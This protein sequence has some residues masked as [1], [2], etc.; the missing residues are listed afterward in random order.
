M[1]KKCD[2]LYEKEKRGRGMK[3]TKVSK[4]IY[5]FT[6]DSIMK[7][8][9]NSSVILTE[10]GPVVIDT[11]GTSKQWKTVEE[12]IKD[13]GYTEPYAVIFTHGH[14]DHSLGTQNTDPYYPIYAHEKA[15]EA[16]SRDKEQRLPRIIAGGYLPSD[17]K[18]IF[19]NVTFTDEMSI[20]A[21][22]FCFKLIHTPG[23]SID[24]ITVYE[25]KSGTVF[26]GD[27][28]IV[29]DDKV[30]IPYF[31]F[32]QGIDEK[33]NELLNTFGK[34]KR[35]EPKIM[36]QGHGF[37]VEPK[38]Y[39]EIINTFVESVLAFAKKAVLNDVDIKNLENTS[40]HDVLDGK[41]IERIYDINGDYSTFKH[42]LSSA[43]NYY[44]IF[45]KQIKRT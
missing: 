15:M 38:G 36:I 14:F 2:L 10:K 35:L 39:F 16:I 13:N 37:N 43:C 27:N 26:A 21:G 19:P 28:I 5:Y 3:K 6:D 1:K 42:N 9:S 4:D 18:V 32:E 29:I 11:F 30:A 23:H 31:N 41:L 17:T 40:P 22:S 20:R 8:F 24:S 12:F 45:P 33:S 25:E 44:R 34:I 7:D